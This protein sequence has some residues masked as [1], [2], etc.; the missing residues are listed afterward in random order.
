MLAVE[1]GSELSREGKKVEKFV[2]FS[3][4]LPEECRASATPIDRIIYKQL[5]IN[6]LHR[7]QEAR[8]RADGNMFAQGLQSV[9]I[10]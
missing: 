3:S 6:I 1:L 4:A 10:V 7:H 2:H 9:A 5:K 8:F